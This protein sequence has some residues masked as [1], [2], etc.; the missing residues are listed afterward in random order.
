MMVG[1][2]ILLF[3]TGD[4]NKDSCQGDSG[5][6]LLMKSGQSKFVNA[7]AKIQE[8]SCTCHGQY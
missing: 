8:H 2:L 5:G 4:L 6:P 7:K 3:T 1:P